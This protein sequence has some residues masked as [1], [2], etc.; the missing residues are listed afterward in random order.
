MLQLAPSSTF[1]DNTG[2]KKVGVCK[3]LGG[4]SRRYA[5]IGG[6]RGCVGE[7]GRAKK[8]SEKKDILKA[9]VVR[10]KRRAPRGWNRHPI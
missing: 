1:A 9:V 6:Y 2:A 3:V 8:S 7:I 4:A 5:Q 10:R